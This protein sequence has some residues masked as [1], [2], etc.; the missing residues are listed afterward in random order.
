MISNALLHTLRLLLHIHTMSE[1]AYV[2]ACVRACTD[3]CVCV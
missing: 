3:V 2:G 1:G